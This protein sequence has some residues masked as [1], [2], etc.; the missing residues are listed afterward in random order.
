MSVYSAPGAPVESSLSGAPTGLAGVLGFRLIDLTDG[1]VALARTTAGIV[2]SPSVAGLYSI[3]VDAP[4]AAGSYA[5][6]WDYGE[7]VVVDVEDLIVSYSALQVGALP[8]ST[9]LPDVAQIR[10]RAADLALRLDDESDETLQ[11]TAARALD[12]LETR[13][14]GARLDPELLSAQQLVAV[15]EAVARQAAMSWRERL[16]DSTVSFSVD[17]YGE[18][19]IALPQRVRVAPSAAEALALRGLIARS[20]T[21][22]PPPIV[23]APAA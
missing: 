1:S 23:A 14:I 11:R 5:R 22:K 20:G 19:R 3:V 21:V 15:R 2:E 9:L 18:Q 13:L 16:E 17:G 8:P 12:T 10:Q 4:L 6:V 7:T